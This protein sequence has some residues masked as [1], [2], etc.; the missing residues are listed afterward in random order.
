MKRKYKLRYRFERLTGG[1]WETA[2]VEQTV[3]ER[4]TFKRERAL[5]DMF[6]VLPARKQK[7]SRS[8]LRR[9]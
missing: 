2:I 8:K 9:T 4:L 1:Y 3:R 6:I 5:N 7:S